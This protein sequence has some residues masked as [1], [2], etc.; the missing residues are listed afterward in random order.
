MNELKKLTIEELTELKNKLEKQL[1]RPYIRPW[2][3]GIIKMHIDEIT[4]EIN[5]R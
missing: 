1:E 2:E 4:E 5:R 3:A